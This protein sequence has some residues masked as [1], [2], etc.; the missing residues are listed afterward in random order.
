MLKTDDAFDT[1]QLDTKIQELK[2]KTDVS[3]QFT[4]KALPC[5]S[6]SSMIFDILAGT[7]AGAIAG[8]ALDK[9]CGTKFIFLSVFIL[10]GF[11]GSF[12]NIYKQM[13]KR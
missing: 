5:K 10:G 6:P 12:Y 4:N 13:S 3:N 8:Y 11:A 9:L 7:A 2:C 1:K